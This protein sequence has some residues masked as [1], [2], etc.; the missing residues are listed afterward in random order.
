MSYGDICGKL[1]QHFTPTKIKIA[2]RFRFY[3]RKQKEDETIVN[4]VAA[5]RNLSKDCQFGS[6]FNSALRDAFVIGLG[7]S[8][9]QM[10]LLSESTLTEATT[11]QA[12]QLRQAETLVYQMWKSGQ[13]WRCGKLHGAY[14]FRFRNLECCKCKKRGHRASKCLQ[15]SG[16]RSSPQADSKRGKNRKAGES[17]VNRAEE[18]EEE[19]SDLELSQLP[20]INNTRAGRSTRPLKEHFIVH[21]K[22]LLMEIDTGAGYTLISEKEWNNTMQLVTY[23]GE[24]VRLIGEYNTR[25]KFR[26]QEKLLPFYVAHGSERPSL[27][28][29]NWL[30]VLRLDWTA[31]LR[32]NTSVTSTFGSSAGGGSQI[33]STPPYSICVTR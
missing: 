10:K 7:D 15:G 17:H 11:Q 26:E 3:Q 14:S 27:C 24:P 33:F 28:G 9:I 25:V 6:F 23:T 32:H 19:Q 13:C 1:T 2:E 31:L 29:R 4:F 22:K 12:K 20:A 8:K 30:R 5:V 16:Q 18:K 21:G